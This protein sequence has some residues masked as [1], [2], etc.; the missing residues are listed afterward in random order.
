MPEDR[1]T[2]TADASQYF[3]VLSRAG[4]A[5]DRFA[6]SGDRIGAGFVRGER[7]IR[8][9]SANIAGALTMS[10]D[11]ATTAII[12]LQGLE[13]VFAIGIGPTIAVAAGI[14]AFEV[15]HEQIKK[16]NE[17]YKDL[18]DSLDAL[19]KPVVSPEVQK[20]QDKIDELTKKVKTLQDQLN[21]PVSKTG[22]F[23]AALAGIASKALLPAF[24]QGPTI[25]ALASAAPTG[26]G[27]ANQQIARV[28]QAVQILANRREAIFYQSLEKLS[29]AIQKTADRVQAPFRNLFQDIGSGQFIKDQTQ[30]TLENVQTQHGQDMVAGFEE[31]QKGGGTLG[32]NAQAMVDAVRKAGANAGFSLQD[33]AHTDFSN[34]DALSKYDFSGLAPLSG[35]TLIV[36]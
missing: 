34:M 28:G 31:F 36:K 24:L 25:S 1:V 15:L 33:L 9:A 10:G 23:F 19:D 32:P 26:P 22:G 20:A 18:K 2:I 14:K 3:D 8:T 11:A 13:R 30:R 17:A 4:V 21:N 7:V 12:A 35:M 27:A 29:E 6:R 16:T 5:S